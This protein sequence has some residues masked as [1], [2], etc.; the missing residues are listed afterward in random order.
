MESAACIE[1]FVALLMSLLCKCEVADILEF[2]LHGGSSTIHLL[3]YSYV[4]TIVLFVLG[5]HF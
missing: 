5:I 4:R 2:F 1:D 3:K